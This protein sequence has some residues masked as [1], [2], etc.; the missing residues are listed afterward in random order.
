MKSNVK[1][2]AIIII[3]VFIGLVSVLIYKHSSSPAKVVTKSGNVI[4]NS[5]V[6]TKYNTKVGYYLTDQKGNTLYEYSGDKKGYSS[7]SG[8]CLVAW[9]AYEVNVLPKKLPA[10]IGYIKRSDTG[11]YQYTYNGLPLYYFL[12]DSKGQINGN[13]IAGFYVAKP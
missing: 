13:G 1:W 6:L 10:G 12:S 9:P 3:I 8:A 4:N 2:L 7:C 11:H 5:I